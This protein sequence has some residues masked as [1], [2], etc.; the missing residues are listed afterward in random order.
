MHFKQITDGFEHG[1]GR[2]TPM[3]LPGVSRCLQ[4]NWL[5]NANEPT[6]AQWGYYIISQVSGSGLS[7]LEFNLLAGVAQDGFSVQEIN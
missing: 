4:V 1:K 6:Y 2:K 7:I 5:C 3:Q